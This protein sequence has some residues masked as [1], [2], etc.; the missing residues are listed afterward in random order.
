MEQGNR[1]EMLCELRYLSFLLLLLLLFLGVGLIAF[2]IFIPLLTLF[3]WDVL[4]KNH[5]L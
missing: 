1:T 4:K 5:L 2:F 3:I